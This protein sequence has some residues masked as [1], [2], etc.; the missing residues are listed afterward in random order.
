MKTHL[1]QTEVHNI[2]LSA[3][4]KYTRNADSTLQTDA[5]FVAEFPVTKHATF[6]GRYAEEIIWFAAIQH[7]GEDRANRLSSQQFQR[8]AKE[9]RKQL[10]LLVGSGYCHRMGYTR[11]FG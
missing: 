2:S 4:L 3:A 10:D 5:S 8:L 9:S 1:S 11:V 7:V 6:E